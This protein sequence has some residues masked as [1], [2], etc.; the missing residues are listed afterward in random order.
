MPW[1]AIV[2]V[3][4]NLKHAYLERLTKSYDNWCVCHN[5]EG[6]FLHIFL[7]PKMFRLSASNLF[8]SEL[9]GRNAA[10]TRGDLDM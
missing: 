6:F 1:E 3:N 9:E 10:F 5:I 8:S 2:E 7:N 4:A